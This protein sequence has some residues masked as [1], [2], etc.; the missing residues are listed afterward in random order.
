MENSL[1]D[2]NTRPPYLSPEKP[3][4]QYKKQKLE[5]DMEQQIASKMGNKYHK[6]AYCPAAYL[7]YM[8]STSC[9]MLSWMTHKLESRLQGEIS[10]T[11]GMQMILP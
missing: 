6:A 11:S 9:E 1:R 10:T 5:P 3:C 7:N 4:M 2:R 8:Q